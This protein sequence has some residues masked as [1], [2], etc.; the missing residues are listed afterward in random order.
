MS[1]LI[2]QVSIGQRIIYGVVIAFLSMAVVAQ[3]ELRDE[4]FSS[5]KLSDSYYKT[6][7]I[8][9]NGIQLPVIED[10]SSGNF[11]TFWTADQNWLINGQVGNNSPSAEFKWSPVLQ[12]YQ[13]AL[14]SDLINGIYF[15]SASNI[16]IDGEFILSFDLKHENVNATG[17]EYLLVEV[18]SDDQWNL[19]KQFSNAN[20]SFEWDHLEIDIT[21]VAFGKVFK[22]RFLA[23]GDDSSDILSWFVDNISI[24]RVCYPPPWVNVMPV[25][26]YTLLVS[27]P[28]PP[29]NSSSNDWIMWDDGTQVGCIG[30]TGGGEFSVASHWDPDMIAQYDGQ[31]I[32][33][34]RFVPGTTVVATDFTLKVWEGAD[35]GTLLYEETLSGLI[36]GDWNEITLSTPIEIDVTQELWFGYTMNSADG[37]FPAGYDAGPAVVGYGDMITFDGVAWDPISSFGTQFDLNWNLQ[38]Y[39]S[40]LTTM[41]SMQ[42]SNISNANYS[43]RELSGYDIYWNENNG[44]GAYEYLDF[45]QDTFYEHYKDP[46]F[47]FGVIYHYMVVAIYED[48]E[49]EAIGHIIWEGTNDLNEDN[50]LLIFPN[51]TNHLVNIRSTVGIARLYFLNLHGHILQ[52]HHLNNQTQTS[53]NISTYDP[54]IY[55]LR[56][57]TEEGQMARKVLV[58]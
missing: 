46:P 3:S 50:E 9:L 45:T 29:N 51:P 32:T 53:L 48:C 12:N 41:E 19:V 27:W 23:G 43:S 49:P 14:T 47:I 21:D 30:L 28:P 8:F 11:G 39:V 6:N 44:V 54:G 52:C 55:L 31:Y 16:Y 37:D 10:W 15:D 5:G 42:L 1:V 7:G 22:L 20:G 13:Q 36:L 58:E 26:P 4:V 38:A 57:E 56:I 35:A 34:I 40:D 33:A 2:N 25:D 18:W 24:E 17:A